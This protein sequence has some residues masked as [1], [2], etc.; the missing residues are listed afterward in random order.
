MDDNS[1]FFQYWIV[2]TLWS[3]C[4]GALNIMV[5]VMHILLCQLGCSM[6]FIPGVSVLK[7]SL[8]LELVGG[9][10]H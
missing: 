4:F 2:E 5:L 3:Y 6:L 8:R 9:S 1:I 7:I 10:W